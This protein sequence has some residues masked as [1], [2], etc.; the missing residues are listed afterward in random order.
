MKEDKKVSGITK[1]SDSNKIS[2]AKRILGKFKGF[3]FFVFFVLFLVVAGTISFEMM[4]GMNK[5]NDERVANKPVNSYNHYSENPRNN[6]KRRLPTAQNAYVLN[7]RFGPYEEVLSYY[8]DALEMEGSQGL[9]LKMLIEQGMNDGDLS[10]K[11]FAE[12][13]TEYIRIRSKQARNR[14]LVAAKDN[15]DAI[16]YQKSVETQDKGF[17]SAYDEYTD[18]LITKMHAVLDTETPVN[19]PLEK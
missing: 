4:Q 11:D 2:F 17:V 10:N 6:T 3:M 14:L 7:R 18:Q 16:I 9:H 12:I 19:Q 1:G 5:S 13:Q 15:P 8:K